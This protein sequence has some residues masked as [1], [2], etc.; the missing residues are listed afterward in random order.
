METLM[1]PMLRLIAP[2]IENRAVS[3]RTPRRPPNAEMRPREYLT[4][5]EINQLLDAAKRNRYGHRNAT[6]ILI[7]YRHG[8]RAAEVC[9][10]RWSQVDLDQARL[11]VRRVKRG[12]PSVHPLQGDELRALRRLKRESPAHSDFVFMTE[13]GGPF[14]TTGFAFLVS[15]AG[16][17][18][19]LPFKAHPHM[20]RHGCGYALI[21]AGAD[22]RALQ[23]YLGHGSPA[24]TARYAQLAAGAFNNF[25]R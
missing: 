24:H 21:N 3:T 22:L 25:W 16:A 5:T 2:T 14:T 11:H 18:A 4:P 1:K 20:L 10:L 6:M 17:K 7:A 23:L 9:D 15:R 8:L 19:G 12:T 13:R